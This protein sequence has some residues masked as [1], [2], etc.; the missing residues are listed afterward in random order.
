VTQDQLVALFKRW[1]KPIR[2]YLSHRDAIPTVD[3]DDL[4]QDVFLR[5]LRYKSDE[6]VENPQGYLFRI[7]S[8]VANEWQDRAV[9]RHPHDDAWLEDLIADDDHGPQT[10][11]ERESDSRRVSKAIDKLPNRA[12][13]ILLMHINDGKTY[14]QIAA[15][16]GVSYRL[17]LRDLT[18]AY[19]TLR[20]KL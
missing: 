7:A 17:V 14:K 6:V 3:L 16:L 4:A 5:L 18:T 1:R 11:A 13:V 20:G 15:E 2:Q 10:E 8:N 12:G 19:G 9:R